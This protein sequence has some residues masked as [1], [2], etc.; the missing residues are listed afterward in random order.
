MRY[1]IERR[2]GSWAVYDSKTGSK[3]STY[4]NYSEAQAEIDRLNKNNP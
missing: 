1:I 4:Y 3:L 2:R